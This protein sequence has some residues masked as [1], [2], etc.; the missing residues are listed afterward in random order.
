MHGIAGPVKSPSATRTAME[1][2]VLSWVGAIGGDAVTHN[3]LPDSGTGIMKLS[4]S[5]ILY[6]AQ[7]KIFGVGMFP[8]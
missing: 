3:M 2:A 8:M 5:A 6:L 1:H 7:G 4:P